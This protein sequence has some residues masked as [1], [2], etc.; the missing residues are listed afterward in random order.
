MEN[1]NQSHDLVAC[2]VVSVCSLSLNIPEFALFPL[3]LV[4]MKV[5]IVSVIKL[6]C[7]R[8]P[9]CTNEN[10]LSFAL[11]HESVALNWRKFTKNLHT[12]K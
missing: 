7:M 6:A 12:V 3:C 8:C 1:N 9:C 5:F 10:I 2:L 11:S 4:Y